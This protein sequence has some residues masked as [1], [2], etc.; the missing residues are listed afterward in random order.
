[1][2]RLPL[3]FDTARIVNPQSAAEPRCPNIVVLK[4]DKHTTDEALETLQAC[5][6]NAE[7]NNSELSRRGLFLLAKLAW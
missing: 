3:R 6:A 1:M 4:I 5:L 7:R 2:V